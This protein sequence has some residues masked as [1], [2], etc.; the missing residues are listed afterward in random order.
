MQTPSSAVASGDQA[1]PLACTD[2]LW[3]LLL[4]LHRLQG[5][6]LPVS[7]ADRDDDSVDESVLKS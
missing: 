5:H 1:N 3:W 6:F 7:G 2:C 4:E